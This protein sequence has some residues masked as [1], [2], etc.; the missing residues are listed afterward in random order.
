MGRRLVQ[1]MT[2]ISIGILQRVC[3]PLHI[4][5]NNWSTLA[6]NNDSTQ[7]T[8]ARFHRIYAELCTSLICVRQCFA[9]LS[10]DSLFVKYIAIYVYMSF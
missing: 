9:I 1:Y 10:L 6:D 5:C 8:F 4:L 3:I 7:Q 2:Q